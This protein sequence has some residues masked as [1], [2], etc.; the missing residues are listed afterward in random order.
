MA[1][2]PTINKTKKAF[3]TRDSVGIESASTTISREICPVVNTVTP[4]PFYWAF[5]AWCYYDWYKNSG[6]N[7][8]RK[9]VN[10]YIR[11]TNYFIALGNLLANGYQEASYTGSQNIYN[12]NSSKDKKY[13]YNPK[14]LTGIGAMGYYPA[15]LDTM[16]MVVTTGRNGEVY[17]EP[18]IEHFDGELLALAFE[19]KISKTEYY[20]KYRFKNI[21]IPADVLIELGKKIKINLDGFNECKQILINNLFETKER[22]KLTECKN[23]INH[24]KNIEKIDLDSNIKCREVFYDFYSSRAKK[25]KLPDEL[26]T[27]SLE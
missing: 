16:G 2:Q 6:K 8:K 10:E 17:Q 25:K 9:E 15:G 21:A 11:K 23:Y 20:K 12:I 3:T 27:I 4:R 24:I 19:K 7:K 22:Y 5:I 14:Y 13:S 18:R 26:K 1:N